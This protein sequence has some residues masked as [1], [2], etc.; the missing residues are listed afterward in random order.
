MLSNQSRR[1]CSYSRSHSRSRSR[2]QSSSHQHRH[3]RARTRSPIL[4]AGSSPTKLLVAPDPE[5]SLHECL[6]AFY[7]K[8]K[9]DLREA[10]GPLSKL[11]FT[12]D[13][14]PKVQ[15]TRL[16]EVTLCVEGQAIKLQSFC[17]DWVATKLH[18]HRRQ[19]R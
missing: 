3:K 9:I 11:H 8:Y 7:S 16:C 2:S 12:P 14:I 13:I 4:S 17:Q 18:Q 6:D 1:G 19:H 5:L 10:K 15:A